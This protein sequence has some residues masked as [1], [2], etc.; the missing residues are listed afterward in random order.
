[1][2]LYNAAWHCSSCMQ[3]MQ[4]LVNKI[5]SFSHK[6]YN[7]PYILNP[8]RLLQKVRKGE[9]LFERETEVFDRVDDNM[10]VP[11]YL[12]QDGNRQKFAYMLDR[13]PQNAN[14]QDT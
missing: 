2:E 10:D 6:G 13:D 3:T 4:H 8:Q 7:D 14:F 1:M 5:E 11:K 12:L 9:D